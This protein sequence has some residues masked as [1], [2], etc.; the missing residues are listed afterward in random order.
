M[1]G[2]NPDMN[3]RRL[4]RTNFQVSVVGFGSCQLRLVPEKQAIDTIITGLTKGINIFH[5]SPEYEGA[6]SLIM[7]GIQESGVQHKIYICS[8]AWGD[9][10]HFERLFEATCENL[11]TDCLDIFGVNSIHDLEM[12]GENVWD[13]GGMVE[14][15]LKKKE[16]GRLKAIFCSSHGSVDYQRSLIEKNVFDVIMMAYNVLGFHVLTFNPETVFKVATPHPDFKGIKGRYDFEQIPRMKSEIFPLCRKNDIGLMIMKPLAGGILCQSN[17]FPHESDLEISNINLPVADIFRY[18]LLN[19]EVSCVIPGT[20]SVEEATENA[21]A[22]TGDIMLSKER[23]HRIK[24]HAEL[25]TQKVCSRCGEC[26]V[27]CSRDLPISWLFRSAYI[28]LSTYYTFENSDQALQYFTLHPDMESICQNC[29]NATCF[30]PKGLNIRDELITIHEKMLRL[31]NNDVV[32]SRDGICS[33][34]PGLKYNYAIILKDVPKT[35]APGN[36][37]VIRI[38]VQN[39]G[40]GT[41]YAEKNTD[42]SFVCLAV[43]LE[44]ELVQIVRLRFDVT[45]GKKTHFAYEIKAPDRQGPCRLK[46]DLFEHDVTFFSEQGVPPLEVTF[47]V[48]S[49]LNGVVPLSSSLSRGHNVICSNLPAEFSTK[50]LP[51]FA[52]K[53]L[54]HN[55]PARVA[56]KT[57]RVYRVSVQNTGTETWYRHHPDGH[58]VAMSISLNG[59]VKS[60]GWLLKNE[61]NPGDKAVVCFAMDI[62]EKPGNYEIKIDMFAQNVTMFEASGSHPLLI[63]IEVFPCKT[64]L[65]EE[66]WKTAR[67][68]NYWFFSP[69]LGVHRSGDLP[70]YPLFASSAKGPRITDVEGREF[71]DLI[72]GWGCSFLGY[73]NERVSNAIARELAS[74]GVIT[75]T[76]YLEMAVSKL[77]TEIIPGAEMTLYGKNGSDVCTAA[78]RMARAYTQR[79]K[80]LVCGYHGWQDWYAE[81]A[82]LKNSG[83]PERSE[84]LV[85]HFPFN[86]LDALKSLLR[87]HAEDIAAVMIDPSGPVLSLDDPF[88][89]VTTDY[90]RTLAD[91]THSVGALLIFDEI[92]CGFRYKTGSVQKAHGV[93]PDLTCLGKALSAG[94]PLSALVGKRKVFNDTL[95][96]ISYSPT[97]KGEVFSFAAAKEAL[98]IYMEEDVPSYIDAFGNKLMSEINSLCQRY[99][100]PAS[101]IG[102]PF[103]MV[104]AFHADDYEKRVMARTLLVQELTKNGIITWKGIFMPSYS[105]SENDLEEIVQA[106]DKTLSVLATAWQKN[107]LMEYLEIPD[108]P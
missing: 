22:G 55:I 16:E 30:C 11:Q 7:K 66:L 29:D 67:D 75:L 92:L 19:D 15:L 69:G 45:P 41:W 34:N 5:T 90:L 51:A 53:Y 107:S 79:K 46:M 40:T 56:A 24:V 23:I 86:D 52:V 74:G 21:L 54:G 31:L 2:I 37:A 12:C 85:I 71:I 73:A 13:K 89:A 98:S 63:T 47:T 87:T 50:E 61:L 14:F 44:D 28:N 42:H 33:V 32:P 95:Y 35:L 64:T 80:I 48:S 18:I 10:D 6:E 96:R 26:D 25:L 20:A 43:Y 4:G 88:H 108:D 57:H 76:H 62:P 39:I 38:Y 72:M 104:F 8:Q 94:M 9:R 59:T 68:I 27:S 17:A 58:F 93:I 3:Y 36:K 91:L 83:I 81:Q 49:G 65:S 105:H 77:L 99:N 60:C 103:R 101:V 102:Y 106:F 70:T 100:V 82:G 1:P 84:A 78:V 97:F